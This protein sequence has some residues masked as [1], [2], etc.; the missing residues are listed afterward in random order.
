MRFRAVVVCSMLA[1][2][3]V[4][5]GSALGQ[6]SLVDLAQRVDQLFRLLDHSIILTD[7]DC[8][9]IGDDWKRYEALDGKMPLASGAHTD[10]REDT[11]T[12]AVGQVGGAYAHQL[13]M[14]EMPSHAHQYRDRFLD[15]RRGGPRLGDDDD[16]DRHYGVDSRTTSETGGGDEHGGKPHENMPPYLVLNFCYSAGS[17]E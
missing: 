2:S 4:W 16:R 5:T 3:L 12:F 14:D 13:K 6:H 10:G 17:P 15:E 8:A 11:R 9:I 1:A 7:Q